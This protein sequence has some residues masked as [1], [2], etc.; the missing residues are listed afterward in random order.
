MLN[1]FIIYE[2]PDIEF[3][4]L[5]DPLSDLLYLD[6]GIDFVVLLDENSEDEILEWA[7]NNELIDEYKDDN[8]SLDLDSLK[9][10]KEEAD[11]EGYNENPPTFAT[12]NGRAF[13]WFNDLGII[14][15]DGVHLID[16]PHPGSDW[17]GVSVKNESC[18]LTLQQFLFTEGY[19]VNFY[20]N[21][22]N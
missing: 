12:P 10:L 8:G 1:Q 18:L 2:N 17:Q 13:D 16:G 20:L 14:L 6:E 21:G 15:P 22:E 19:K 11:L 3:N 9:E 7:E 4:V 5:V